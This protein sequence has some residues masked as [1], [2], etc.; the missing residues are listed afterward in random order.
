[1]KYHDIVELSCNLLLAVIRT[2]IVSIYITCGGFNTC[3]RIPK[4]DN[5]LLTGV[6]IQAHRE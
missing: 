1:M 2:R 6:I 5:Q 3:I 4:V